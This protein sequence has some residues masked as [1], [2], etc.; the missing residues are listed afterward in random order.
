MPGFV[1]ARCGVITTACM[2]GFVANGPGELTAA[3]PEPVMVRCGPPTMR[4]PVK[5]SATGW[6]ARTSA[7]KS[8]AI[9]RATW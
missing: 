8:A 4:P 1:S 9:S 5:V 6:L 7:S 2:L 3:M